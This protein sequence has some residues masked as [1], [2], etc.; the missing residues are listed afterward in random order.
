MALINSQIKP[1]LSRADSM[2]A[3]PELFDDQAPFF[4]QRTGLP[5][6]CCRDIAKIV[7]EIGKVEPDDLVV[8]VAPGTGQIGQWFEAPVRYIGFDLSAGMLKEFQRRSSRHI[9]DRALIQ[10]DANT[11]WPLADGA[12]RVIFSS[13]AMHLLD[14]ERVASE[15]FR[16]GSSAGAI[17]MLGRV[18]RNPD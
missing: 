9:S 2:S 10:A 12:A 14:H 11:F 6:D 18:E 3:S 13:R 7:I 4:E 16:I 5:E 1:A 17:F 15:V 8:E